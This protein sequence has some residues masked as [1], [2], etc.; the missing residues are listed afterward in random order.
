MSKRSYAWVIVL[1]V[2][3]VLYLPDIGH[4]QPVAKPGKIAVVMTNHWEYPD[5]SDTT[6]L[7]L[8]E[9]THFY[10][11]ARNA[12]Y[13]MDFVSPN[14][15]AVPLDQRSQGC[16]YVDESARN[17]LE[18]PEFMRRLKHTKAAAGVNPSAYRAIYYTGGHGVMWDYRGNPGLKKLGE[19]IYRQG[20]IIATVCHGGAGLIDLTDK[21][22]QAP[23]FRPS[24]DRVFQYGRKTVRT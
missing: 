4:C 3:T 20:G 8:T 7:W 16:L 11:I 6:G 9:L 1:L 18:D 14:G 21:K 15:G 12:D 13:D 5:R 23:G 17:H 24:C 22:W 10:D 2:L 19:S